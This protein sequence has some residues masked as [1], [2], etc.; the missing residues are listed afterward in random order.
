MLS[1]HP[2]NHIRPDVTF[3]TVIDTRLLH[4]PTVAI[5]SR[6]FVTHLRHTAM[7]TLPRVDLS[8]F[9]SGPVARL[10]CFSFELD[11]AFAS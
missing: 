5:G 2:T 3:K 7:G 9:D 11:G 1:S 4:P 8:R 6:R 10:G